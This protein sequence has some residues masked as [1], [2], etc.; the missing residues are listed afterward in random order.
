MQL[1]H[2]VFWSCPVASAIR[3]TLAS[4]LPPLTPL[5]CSAVWLLRA[6][7]GLQAEVWAVVCAAAVEAMAFGHRFLWALQ[8]GQEEQD[9]LLDP[10][11]SLITAFFPVVPAPSQPPEDPASVLV[12]RASHRA[13]AL[14]WSYLVEFVALAKVLKGWTAVST[15]HPF[16]GVLREEGSA[17]LQLN[18]PPGVLWEHSD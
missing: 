10:T 6:P 12:R 2:H 1:Q 16:L 8:R 15:T 17:S 9:E 14:F 4:A 11:Q 18:L 7:P 5:P 3:A 13:V